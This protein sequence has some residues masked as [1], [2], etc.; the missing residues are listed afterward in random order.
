MC[1]VTKK[2]F[3]ILPKE[4]AF[5]IENGYPIPVLSPDARNQ[6][7][8][9]GRLKRTTHTD[10][11]DTCSAPFQTSYERQSTGKILCEECFLQETG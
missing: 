11:C 8:M 7:R 10:R 3:K 9:K 6:I 2:P 4:L 5:Y 1:Q